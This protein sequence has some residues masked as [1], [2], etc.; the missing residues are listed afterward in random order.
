MFLSHCQ[1]LELLC[2]LEMVFVT[3]AAD[4]NIPHHLW[5]LESVSVESKALLVYKLPC[6]Q[7]FVVVC[8]EHTGVWHGC[9]QK[10]I[11]GISLIH[12]FWACSCNVLMQLFHIF[13]HFHHFPLLFLVGALLLLFY[14]HAGLCQHI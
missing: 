13:L 1:H 2:H 8:V 5:Q 9:I 4:N 12:L 10:H 3:E 6:H 11:L 7:V 14:C